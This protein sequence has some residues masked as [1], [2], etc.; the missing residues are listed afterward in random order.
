[1]GTC[2][3]TNA[4][5]RTPKLSEAAAEPRERGGGGHR[6][7]GEH[8]PSLAALELTASRV[9]RASGAGRARAWIRPAIGVALVLFAVSDLA[10]GRSA[11]F[12]CSPYA[13]SHSLLFAGVAW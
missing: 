9:Q 4:A 6:A 10:Q 8:V 12:M 13:L 2:A 7:T 11:R 1:M 3:M 5:D